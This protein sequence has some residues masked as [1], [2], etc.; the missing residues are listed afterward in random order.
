MA[1]THLTLEEAAERLGIS[2]EEFKRNLKMHPAFKTLVPI[3]DGSTLRFKA[4]AIEELARELG[5]GSNPENPL[6]TIP[7]GPPPDSDDFEVPTHK[8][9]SE[10][11]VEHKEE[12][13]HERK[14]EH[15]ANGDDNQG[16]EYGLQGSH[17]GSDALVV[18][19]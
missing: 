5:A 7:A 13:K 17:V 15:S 1:A 10:S 4:A 18:R 19:G 9:S 11:R 16:E 3:R 12:H 14:E 2:P 8:S 6:P